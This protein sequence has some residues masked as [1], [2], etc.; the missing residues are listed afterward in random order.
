MG[1][2]FDLKLPAGAK[3]CLVA[4]AGENGRL[5]VNLGTSLSR[6][7]SSY[8]NSGLSALLAAFISGCGRQTLE[9]IV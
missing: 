2:A 4:S 5:R 9:F 6:P 3:L 7:Q 1:T 8:C